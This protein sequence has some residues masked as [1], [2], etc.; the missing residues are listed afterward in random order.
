MGRLELDRLLLISQLHWTSILFYDKLWHNGC[1]SGCSS[2]L[3]LACLKLLLDFRKLIQEQLFFFF[4]LHRPEEL[5]QVDRGIGWFLCDLRLLRG[6]I[7]LFLACRIFRLLDLKLPHI[8][9]LRCLNHHLCITFN[10]LSLMR[11]CS[12]S[13][14]SSL[15]LRLLLECL[16]LL[17]SDLFLFKL[18]LLDLCPLLLF[19]FGLFVLKLLLLFFDLV[20]L[21]KHHLESLSEYLGELRVIL[22]IELDQ[23]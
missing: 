13:G 21:V 10:Y 19:D 20:D 9:L 1:S 11:G 8:I 23:G 7:S 14:S 5:R 15:L 6:L 17:L 2:N 12:C 3:L 16:L 4:W 18:L 22:E